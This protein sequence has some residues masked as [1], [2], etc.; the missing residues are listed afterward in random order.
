MLRRIVAIPV[1]GMEF[2]LFGAAESFRLYGGDLHFS[3]LFDPGSGRDGNTRAIIRRRTLIISSVSSTMSVLSGANPKYSISNLV[4]SN[5]RILVERLP[6]VIVPDC[7]RGGD[8]RKE[9]MR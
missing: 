4:G 3:R 6:K 8:K 7:D 9:A 2:G 5:R 1:S